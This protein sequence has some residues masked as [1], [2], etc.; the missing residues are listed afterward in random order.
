M[1]CQHGIPLFETQVIGGYHIKKVLSKKAGSAVFQASHPN[2]SDSVA[3]KVFSPCGAVN[4]RRIQSFL[5]EARIISQITHPNIVNFY[6]YG[7][8]ENYLYIAMEYVEGISLRN[9]ILSQ[10]ISLPR[11]LEIIIDVA[12]AV[13]H[14][15]S[16]NILHKDIKPENILIKLYEGI[17]LID[18]G[19]AVCK[20][21]TNSCPP[22]VLGTPYYMSPEQWQ[23]EPSSPASDIY[24]LGLLA[25]ELILGNLSLGKVHLSLIPERIG[26]I[27]AKAL[28]P[29]PKAR[30]PSVQQLI[31]DLNYY[32]L[33]GEMHKD[34]RKKDYNSTLCEQLQKQQV[35]LSPEKLMLPDFVSGALYKQGYP[36]CPYVYY[37]TFITGDVLNVWL[38][39][40]PTSNGVLA[41]SVVKTLVSQQ[42][43]QQPFLEKICKINEQLIRL[44]VPLDDMGISLLYL[45]IPKE[46][47][48]LTW[49]ACGKT[50]F[51]LK[52]Q[53]KVFRNYES[54]SPGLGKINSLQIRETKVAWEIGD[55]AVLHTL[56]TDETSTFLQASTLVE[57]KDRRQ[58]AIFCPIESMC[59]KMQN[60]VNENL[61][62]S[63]LISLK[64]IR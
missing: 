24:A 37:D 39:Y 19:L 23:G 34:L 44:Q 58:M 33:S 3:I 35:W 28:Q 7:K 8:W 18:F 46:K 17:K 15:H 51:W 22:G 38:S 63:T 36:T 30:Y 9:Y 10:F 52:K 61:S 26:K 45:A 59:C 49:I 42:F 2:I 31:A 11:A 60:N 57:L 6:H 43:F 47:Y 20:D 16:R 64:R 40:S 4:S 27:L 32:R 13:E 55:E 25:Y 53:G 12:Y 1:D 29:L 54:F 41:L 48:E 50:V 14:L 21:E 56:Q 5:K 62:L